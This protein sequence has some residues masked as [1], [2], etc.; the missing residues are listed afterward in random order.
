MAVGL[1][2]LGTWLAWE[3]FKKTPPHLDAPFRLFPV[4]ILKPL[5]GAD[6]GLEENLRTFFELDYP[7][8]E[9]LFSIADLKDPACE[10]LERLMRQYPH[11]NAQV[12]VG[13]VDVGPNPK[14]NNLLRSY[15]EAKYDW[16]L[17]S[18]SNVR[19][20]QDYLK[21]LVANLEPGVGVLTAVVVGRSAYGLGGWLEAV[22]LNTFYARGMILLQGIGKA[23]VVGKSMLFQRSVA[24]R[25]GGIRTLARYLAEDYVAGQAMRRLNLK[26]LI[27][28][29]PIEQH[30]GHYSIREFW[31]RHLRW[32]RLR[33][34]QAFLAFCIEP[35]FSSMFSGILGSIAFHFFLGVSIPIFVLSHL[36]FW[37]LCDSLIYWRLASTLD[38]KTPFVWLLRELLAFP[39]WVHTASGNT[40]M[41]RG[42]RLKLLSGGVLDSFYEEG[43]DLARLG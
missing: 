2:S 41:W 8:F 24:E 20:Q 37:W 11:V 16:I 12:F 4:S 9:L 30:L 33:K 21:R 6:Q 14:V 25:F 15:T 36:L 38:F 5:K 34:S 31:L 3:H 17:I 29:D 32:G 35:L 13:D 28:T 1:N 39:L 7:V 43:R 26:T 42:N 22:Y 10:V 27:M 23:P 18:D 40:V 19:V